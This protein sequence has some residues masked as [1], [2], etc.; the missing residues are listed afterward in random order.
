MKKENLPSLSR[1]K[2]ALYADW[3]L[4]VR[5]R[6]EFRCILCGAT[7]NL[8]AHHWYCSDH[9]AHAAR[10]C[11]DNGATLCYACHIRG[12]HHR[13]D[14]VS[15]SEISNA[16]GFSMRD[17]SHIDSLI[18]MDVST[19]FLRDSWDKMRARTITIKP[20]EIVEKLGKVFAYDNSHQM[21]VVDNV[22][23]LRSDVTER[24]DDTLYTVTSIAKLPESRAFR[25]TL[26]KIEV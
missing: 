24:N 15:V 9:H 4:R 2:K 11:V 17:L 23:C 7:E 19:Q 10:Y 13:A 21:A 6:D 22:V 5:T 12:V 26:K 8:T 3:S 1:I 25:Y 16:L 14:F 20:C 18:D